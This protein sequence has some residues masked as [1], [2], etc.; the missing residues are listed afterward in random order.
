MKKSKYVDIVL[1]LL[2]ILLLQ[3]VSESAGIVNVY[4]SGQATGAGKEQRGENLQAWLSGTP[5]RYNRNNSEKR[6]SFLKTLDSSNPPEEIGKRKRGMSPMGAVQLLRK[7]SFFDPVFSR[8]DKVMT[9]QRFFV[10]FFIDIQ[11]DRQNKSKGSE[12]KALQPSREDSRQGASQEKYWIGYRLKNSTE[13]SSSNWFVG[14]GTKNTSSG[15]KRKT[16]QEDRN[17]KDF[18]GPIIGLVGKF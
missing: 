12:N 10:P 8:W 13:D 16:N 3:N 2:N 11:S 15:D 5:F 17:K 9:G 4:G 6:P 7:Y 1:L 14:F 18:N